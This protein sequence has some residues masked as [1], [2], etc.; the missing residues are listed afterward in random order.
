MVDTANIPVTKVANSKLKDLN[1]VVAFGK[2]FT[3]HLLEAGIKRRME[4]VP[5]NLMNLFLSARH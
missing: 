3:D 5:S 4:S 1:F 2:Q